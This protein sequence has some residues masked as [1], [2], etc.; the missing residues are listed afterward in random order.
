MPQNC[1]I[2]FMVL[3]LNS[4][5]NE[6]YVDF[7]AVFCICLQVLGLF[8]NNLNPVFMRDERIF[9]VLYINYRIK[10]EQKQQHSVCI[11]AEI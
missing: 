3:Y 1:P 9:S 5:N 10:S 4:H 8:L 2:L 7:S 11:A 6:L